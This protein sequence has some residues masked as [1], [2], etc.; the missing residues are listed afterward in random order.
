[1]GGGLRASA[2]RHDRRQ[3]EINM[4]APRV[5]DVGWDTPQN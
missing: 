3:C 4:A 2:S 5:I 1:M